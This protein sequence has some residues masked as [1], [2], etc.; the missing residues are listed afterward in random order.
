M[1]GWIISTCKR[2]LYFPSTGT[3]S[4]ICSRLFSAGSRVMVVVKIRVR[5]SVSVN[6]VRVRMA[7]G[8]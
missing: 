3:D 1:I 2:I 4:W 5:F 8:K 7:D 6:R